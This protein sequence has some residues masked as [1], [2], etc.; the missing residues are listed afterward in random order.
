MS[1]ILRS[2]VPACDQLHVYPIP[3][4]PIKAARAVRT[5]DTV[6]FVDDKG[7]IYS[8][9]I[10]NGFSFPKTYNRKSH[11]DTFACLGKL[12][13]V[14]KEQAAEHK[15]IVEQESKAREDRCHADNILNSAERLGLNLT[16]AQKARLS[17]IV[18]DKQ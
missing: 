8:T 7:R 2:K 17:V 18:G 4:K 11:L 13:V 6:V 9:G 14:S 1:S 12:G 10:S 16:E 5:N 3:V 15:R